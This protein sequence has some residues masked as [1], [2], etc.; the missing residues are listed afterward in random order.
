MPKDFEPWI[1]Q[2][3]TYVEPSDRASRF[4]RFCLRFFASPRWDE[5]YLR[6]LGAVLFMLPLEQSD[7]L[8]DSYTRHLPHAIALVFG[9]MSFV[10]I[11][12]GVVPCTTLLCRC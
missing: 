5:A 8:D 7:L 2:P 3:Q 12:P 6:L 1:D 4:R 9:L 10:A 11:V